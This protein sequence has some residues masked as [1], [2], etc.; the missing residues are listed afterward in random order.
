MFSII[1]TNCNVINSV[2]RHNN[3]TVKHFYITQYEMEAVTLVM[4]TTFLHLPYE[5][6]ISWT[7][8]MFCAIILSLFSLM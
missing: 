2:Y 4:V 8:V 1:I 7:D 6:I 3:S 5:T